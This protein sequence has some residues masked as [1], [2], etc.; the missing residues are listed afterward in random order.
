MAYFYQLFV[1]FLPIQARQDCKT[2]QTLQHYSKT[3]HLNTEDIYKFYYNYLACIF[4][5]LKLSSSSQSDALS[6]DAVSPLSLTAFFWA[7]LVTS[8]VSS[9]YTIKVS[10]KYPS[11]VCFQQNLCISIKD[12]SSK[13]P[14]L[15]FSKYEQFAQLIY[16]QNS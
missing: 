15:K 9:S 11:F 4:L 13:F 6:T 2:R 7:V 8:F 1:L 10:E 14:D 5:P 16:P 12:I 3:T